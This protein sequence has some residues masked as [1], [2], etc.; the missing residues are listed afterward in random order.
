MD[1]YIPLKMVQRGSDTSA[2]FGDNEAKPE[3]SC[4]KL[5]DLTKTVKGK[6]SEEEHN[7]C[8]RNPI[9]CKHGFS[10]SIFGKLIFDRKDDSKRYLFS[11]GNLVTIISLKSGRR[12]YRRCSGVAVYYKGIYLYAVVSTGEKL[13]SVYVAGLVL[14]DTWSN[15]AFTWSQ[16]DGLDL[17]IN[18]KRK[19]FVKYPESLPQPLRQ[20]LKPLQ[21]TVGAEELL[22]TPI[23]TS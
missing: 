1:R 2:D 6:S 5:S 19:A 3:R 23:T 22:K 13:W 17:Y 4:L 18:G 8:W 21:L 15:V 12:R 20:P 11:T 16:Q 10:A 9:N 14:N 7:K